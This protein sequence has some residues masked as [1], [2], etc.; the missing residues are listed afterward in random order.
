MKLMR[1]LFLLVITPISQ[2]GAHQP[3]L[4]ISDSHTKNSPYVVEK[5][6]ISKAIYSRLVGQSHYYKIF[7]NVSFDFYAGITK[8]KLDDCT[9]GKIFSLELLDDAFNKLAIADG[10]THNWQPWF[11]EFGRKWY[12]VGPEIGNNFR[13]TTQLEAG[14]YYIRVYNSTNI[15]NYVLAIG[16]IESFPI[17]VITRM[18]R[19]LPKINR[20]FWTQADCRS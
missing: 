20:I 15:G 3:V 13:P 9:V 2:V 14:T 12:W 17:G 16:H 19:D 8:P 10:S 7:S 18:V 6:E 4:A 1:L 5:P 11:E